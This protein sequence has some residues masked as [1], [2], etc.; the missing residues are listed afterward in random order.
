MIRLID[1]MLSLFHRPGA[2]RA[3]SLAACVVGFGGAYGAA[4]G[5]YGIRGGNAWQVAFSASKVP[6][7]LLV[8]FALALPSFF[9]MNTLVGTRDDFR[10]ALRAHVQAQAAITL[11]LASLAPL[12]LVWYASHVSYPLAVLFNAAMFGLAAI[13]GQAVLRRLYRPLIA[14]NRRHR[15]LLIAWLLMYAFVGIQMG[16]VLRPFVG[17]PGSP[18]RFFRPG[19]WGNAYVEVWRLISQVL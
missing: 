12:T 18:V 3:R 16:W 19:A 10:A 7:L 17:A 9:V 4:M 15:T 5:L 13:A 11:I 14:R 6:L 8:T 1:P 2:Y